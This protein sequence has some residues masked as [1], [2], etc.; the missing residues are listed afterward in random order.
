MFI[1]KPQHHRANKQGYVKVADLVLESKLGR[2]LL[3]NEVAHHINENK[4]DDRPENL[5]VMDFA[6]HAGFHKN[7]ALQSKWSRKHDQCKECR[8][9]DKPHYA[10]GLCRPCYRRKTRYHPLL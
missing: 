4:I 6:E 5:N 1:K 10:K 9:I 3:P 2:K 7:A 8:N